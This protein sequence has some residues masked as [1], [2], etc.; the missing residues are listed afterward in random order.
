MATRA[1]I[2]T[3]EANQSPEGGNMFVHV[4]KTPCW[5]RAARS[6]GSRDLLGCDER[7]KIEAQLA[8]ERD[9]LRSLLEN[10][11]D[12][13][14]FKDVASRFIRCSRSMAARL[15]LAERWTWWA[16]RFRFSSPE[17]AQGYYQ[18]EQRIILT[19]KPLINK[20][21]HAVD[22]EGRET[23]SAVTKVPVHN[24]HGNITG[25]VASRAMSPS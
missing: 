17:I 3:I 11:P 12:R 7:K 5:T 10:I 21:Q 1:A 6:T 22:A 13:I 19:G 15:G 14:Y 16:D 23:W 4:I 18:E 2:D 25:I 24:R 9:L 20:L 8:Y